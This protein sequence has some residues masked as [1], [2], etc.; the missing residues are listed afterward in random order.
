M[1]A[2]GM[3]SLGG[4]RPTGG[5]GGGGAGISLCRFD[6]DGKF[7]IALFHCGYTL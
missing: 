1:K 3:E 6:D 2:K 5:G 7:E 4:R